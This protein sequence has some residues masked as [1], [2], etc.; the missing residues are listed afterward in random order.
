MKTF[1]N[2]LFLLFIIILTLISL[3]YASDCSKCTP[4]TFPVS[5]GKN[6]NGVNCGKDCKWFQIDS[7]TAKCLSCEV[8]DDKYYYTKSLTIDGQDIYCRKLGI[9]GFPGRKIIFGTNQIVTDC[10]ELG[11]YHLGDVCHHFVIENAYVSNKDTKELKCKY[12]NYQKTF[13]NGLK[14]YICLSEEK[15]CDAYKENER[16]SNELNYFDADT[17]ECL[18]I[19]PDDKIRIAYYLH[20]KENKI[21]YQCSEKCDKNG[22][23][24]EYTIDAIDYHDY[25][26][27]ITYCYK[28]C[29]KERPYYY[30]ENDGTKTCVREC[31]RFK[32]K[33]EFFVSSDRKCSHNIYDC[34][35]SFHFLVNG[36]KKHFECLDGDRDIQECEYPYPYRFLYHGITYCLSSCKDSENE[37][38]EEKRKTY[39]IIEKNECIYGETSE[40]YQDELKRWVDCKKSL[41][42]PFHDGDKCVRKCDTNKYIVD[43]TYECVSECD[44][45]RYKINDETK[46]CYLNCPENIGMGFTKGNYC[47]RCEKNK[48]GY[49][50]KGQ[51]ECI[52]QC[53]NGYFYEND[54]N[55][56]HVENCSKLK[57]FSIKDNN[58]CY[59]SCSLI[60]YNY[61]YILDFQ[62]YNNIDHIDIKGKYFYEINSGKFRYF[63]SKT[64]AITECYKKGY[65]YINNLSGKQCIEKCNN[66][67]CNSLPS[68]TEFG[69]CFN[70]Q[71]DIEDYKYYNSVTKICSKSCDGYIVAN[72]VDSDPVSLGSNCVDKCPSEYPYI[73]LGS[74]NQYYCIKE[75]SYYSLGENEEKYCKDSCPKYYFQENGIKKCVD[76]CSQGFDSN[77]YPIFIYSHNKECVTSCFT[78]TKKFSI[79]A[80]NKPQDCL[81]ECPPEA[82]YYYDDKKLCLRKCDKYYSPDNNKIC[83][84]RCDGNFIHPGNIC[85]SIKCPIEYSFYIPFDNAKLCVINCIDYTYNFF[86]NQGECLKEKNTQKSLYGLLVNNC[87]LDYKDEGGICKRPDKCPKKIS[88]PCQIEKSTIKIVEKESNNVY[89]NETSKYTE[90]INTI[91]MVDSTCYRDV[92]LINT[93]F[94]L[95]NNNNENICVIEESI[96]SCNFITTTNECV[97]QCPKGENFV[98]NNKFCKNSCPKFY[99]EKRQSLDGSYYIYNCIDSCTINSAINGKE[100]ITCNNNYYVYDNLCFNKTTDL[101]NFYS[102]LRTNDFYSIIYQ[103]N[104]QDKNKISNKLC[105][106]SCILLTYRIKDNNKCN[107]KCLNNKYLTLDNNGYSCISECTNG[108]KRYSSYKVCQLKCNYLNY[109]SFECQSSCPKNKTLIDKETFCSNDCIVPNYSY[110]YLSTDICLSSCNLAD[111]EIEGKKICIKN[112]DSCKK[113]DN[114]EYFYYEFDE[115]IDK[116]LCVKTCKENKKFLRL[117]KHC[118]SQCDTDPYEDYYYD[119]ENFYCMKTCQNTIYPFIDGKVCRKQ[120]SYKYEK[121]NVCVGTCSNIITNYLDEKCSELL[122]TK[123]CSCC[124]DNVYKYNNYCT[125]ICP[126]KYKFYYINEMERKECETDCP[127]KYKYY[128]VIYDS[129]EKLLYQ[130]LETCDIEVFDI[131]GY[132]LSPRLCFNNKCQGNYPFFKKNGN[133]LICYAECPA[134]HMYSEYNECFGGSC[135]Y[136]YR[137]FE[138][139]KRCILYKDMKYYDYPQKKSV[140]ICPEGHKFIYRETKNVSICLES[141]RSYSAVEKLFLNSKNRCVKECKDSEKNG[142]NFRCD[143]KYLYF[144]NTFMNM[145]ICLSQNE[146]TCENIKNFPYVFNNQCVSTCDG[147]LSLNGTYCYGSS[148]IVCPN[149]SSRQKNKVELYQCICDNRFYYKTADKQDIV[150]LGPDIECGIFTYEGKTYNR[151]LLI[152]G[153]KQCVEYCPFDIY[154]IEFGSLCIDK[155]PENAKLINNKCTC[156]DL[157]YEKEGQHFCLQNCNSEYPLLINETRECVKRCPDNYVYYKDICYNDCNNFKETIKFENIN[158]TNHKIKLLNELYGKKG[159]NVCFCKGTWYYNE[160]T[161]EIGCNEDQMDSCI[162]FI[163]LGYKFFTKKILRC[164]KQCQTDYPYFFNDNCYLNCDEENKNRPEHYKLKQV[165]NTYEC[166]CI[167]F[168]KYTEMNQKECVESVEGLCPNQSLLIKNTS[169]CH[170]G[171][172][173]PKG[174]YFF[175]NICYDYCPNNTDNKQGF[176]N[177]CSCLYNWYLDDKNNFVCLNEGE[178]CPSNNYPN[179]IVST[180]QCV[181]P[182]DPLLTGKYRFNKLFYDN[183]CPKNTTANNEKDRICVCIPSYGLWYQEINESPEKYTN[184]SCSV[185]NCPSDLPFIDETNNECIEKCPNKSYN[186]ICYD[187][188]PE[189]TEDKDN[190]QECDIITE[191]DSNN[192]TEF[193]EK[194]IESIPDL[195]KRA[196]NQK[197]KEINRTIELKNKNGDE[198]SVLLIS[199]FY[200]IN[201]NKYDYQSEHNDKN[202]LSG[203]LS[204]ID[205]SQCVQNLYFKNSLPA[206]EDIVIVKFDLVNTPK[207]YLINPVEYK[208]INS[209]TGLTIDASP[210]ETKKILISYPFF[211]ILK[212]YDNLSKQKRN[213]ERFNIDIKSDGDLSTLEEKYNLGKKINELYPDIDTFNSKDNLYTDYCS[214][215]KINDKNLVIEDRVEELYPHYS[216]CEHNCTYNRTDFKGQRIYCLCDL[217]IEFDINRTHSP[218]IEIN[219][220]N[221]SVAQSGKTNFPVLKCLSIWK[222]INRVFKNNYILYYHLIVIVLEIVLL[223]LIILIGFKRLHNFLE[224]KV[225]DIDHFVDI[226]EKELDIDNLDEKK[227]KKN[228]KLKIRNK[229]ILEDYIQ[230]TEKN[231]N[232]PPKKEK[233]NEIQ[234]IPDEFIFLYFNEK[235]RGVRKKIERDLLPFDVNKNTKL[236]L[237][238]IDG[239]DYSDVKAS[240]PFKEEQNLLEIIDE[241][242]KNE[243]I[244]KSSKKSDKNKVENKKDEKNNEEN[245]ENQINEIIFINNDKKGENKSR[246]IKNELVKISE[247]ESLNKEFTYS[248]KNKYVINKNDEVLIDKGDNKISFCDR[249]EIEHRL[250]RSPYYFVEK[251]S[252]GF[253]YF[254]LLIFVEILDKIYIVKILFFRQRYDILSLNL[255]IYLL[256]HVFLLNILAMFFDIRTIKRMWRDDNY[257][258]YTFYFGF[259]VC[260]I[261]IVW[262]LYIVFTCV[263]TNKGKYNEILDIEKAKKPNKR[264]LIQKKAKSLIFNTKIKVTFY[265]ILQFIL[266]IFFLLYSSTLC[267]IFSVV[268]NKLCIS[269]ILALVIEA[270]FK[271]AYGLILAIL[272][273]ISLCGKFKGLYNFVLFMDN[274][275]L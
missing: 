25:D 52:S 88:Y 10:L 264:V 205:L 26:K 19:C 218:N 266:L 173:C 219:D 233:N 38:F 18:V 117:N 50:I 167:E 214:P 250:L 95:I 241:N 23:D 195:Y 143:C 206:N 254:L 44:I 185:I 126:K 141:C 240:G 246:K 204:Y 5:P 222:D 176:P 215:L 177:N 135:P 193:T 157:F 81:D 146:T 93:Y 172:E 203:S 221:I 152:N 137:Q 24:K 208:F 121:N 1:S 213:L 40:Y 262:I 111:Y 31:N 273:Q 158:S 140:H 238:K 131:S 151:S 86:N 34:G 209:R 113:Y 201:L 48:N 211:D 196:K 102:D 64:E 258:D 69:I 187:K 210:C 105:N 274:Y 155:C 61:K 148:S 92:N 188:C 268:L 79:K 181:K 199:E 107:D 256:H 22:Y 80:I 120:C 144:K 227:I 20:P 232:N 30:I 239:V 16:K 75:C 236:L 237:Q 129:A 171:S 150:C 263:M 36:D 98:E 87:G 271:I 265:L 21:Y 101:Y 12:F 202:K 28:L 67:Y 70:S 124:D 46:T 179:L 49:Y 8:E 156:V 110:N 192:I 216:L 128:K 55:V 175:N 163:D 153:T 125:P 73:K 103:N 224:N 217:K 130:C 85:T 174:Y 45:T 190:N 39:L 164:D 267:V 41:L 154:T 119:E 94:K 184:Y 248:R 90:E 47:V 159:N 136:E 134:D 243:L 123:K 74:N 138:T 182:G 249:I 62:C 142:V 42:G 260:A 212:R 54:N 53:P 29:P 223:L 82:P 194:I 198:S 72:N 104:C 251:K 170:K 245:N 186:G 6:C 68:K 225:C 257:P 2:N 112:G 89:G 91:I 275:I 165:S 235:D 11:L 63:N 32:D 109:N 118:D 231:L 162:S 57:K 255:S 108:N 197:D 160:E 122:G 7:N 252:H 168:W 116:N 56:C 115:S 272:R 169:E 161:K 77:G 35:V 269:Y 191:Y 247:K 229:H 100:C 149:Y 226:N 84:D 43:N 97:D 220:Y 200:N 178:G 3:I 228:K 253:W 133:K 234:F 58:I 33:H 147:T 66:Y 76:Y 242:D 145:R 51:K 71:T 15:G 207:E 17:K 13:E 65:K 4:E 139:T 189:L 96:N 114:T 59:S 180:K 78:Y 27:T 106:D 259:S 9:N 183:G 99:S 127:S 270:M 14:T 261:L 132:N 60:N 166:Q 37:F 244:S 83:I 230:T